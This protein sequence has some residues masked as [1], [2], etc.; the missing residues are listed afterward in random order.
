MTP[1][2]GPGE[3]NSEELPGLNC[4]FVFTSPAT[5]MDL[6]PRRT[7]AA[8]PVLT[9]VYIVVWL[10]AREFAGLPVCSGLIKERLFA[11]FI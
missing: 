7:N 2:E 1:R 11:S 10:R 9:Q 8:V 4:I 6:T 3:G 5:W